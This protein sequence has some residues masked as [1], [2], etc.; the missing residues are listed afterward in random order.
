MK[1]STSRKSK[2]QDCKFAKR[3]QGK[4]CLRKCERTCVTSEAYHELMRRF[5]RCIS[6]VLL[7]SVVAHNLSRSLCRLAT[8]AFIDLI[9]RILV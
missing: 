3:R 6:M 5:G 4:I 9:C 7:Y 8:V 1:G 2:T